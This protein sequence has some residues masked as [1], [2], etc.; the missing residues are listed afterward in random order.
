M[1]APRSLAE[2]FTTELAFS[3]GA[4]PIRLRVS[5]RAQRVALRIDGRGQAVELVLPHRTPL[6]SGL[7][8]L[9]KNR[10]WVEAR[11]K[12]LPVRVPFRDGAVIPI[13]GTKYRIRHMKRRAGDQG[14][15]WIEDDEL[16]VTGDSAH[17]PRRVRDFLVETARREFSRRARAFA[18]KVERKVGRISIRD[19]TSR[20]GSCSSSGSLAFSW[21]LIFAPEGVVTYIIA[22]EVCHLVV[23]NHGPRFWRLV[24]SLVPDARFRQDWLRRNR[25]S[26]MRFG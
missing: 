1:A 8:F 26:L 12:D 9:D 15:V 17:L 22:H 16:R 2:A 5:G 24:E 25:T 6:V 19:M 7:K 23:M 21:R 10:D 14:P 11:L 18:Q 3:K 20:W 13:L 4:V